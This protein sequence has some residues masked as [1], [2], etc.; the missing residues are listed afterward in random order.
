M[1]GDVDAYLLY[2]Q[3]ADQHT[4]EADPQ[5]EPAEVEKE[6]IRK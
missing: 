5:D 3:I 6:L 2:K 1:T 4:D